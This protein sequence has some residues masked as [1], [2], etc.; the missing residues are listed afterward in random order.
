MLFN[1]GSTRTW[2]GAQ[3]EVI[4]F[5]LFVYIAFYPIVF[6]FFRRLTGYFFSLKDVQRAYNSGKKDF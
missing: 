5:L 4:P 2:E 3:P 1:R 6:D